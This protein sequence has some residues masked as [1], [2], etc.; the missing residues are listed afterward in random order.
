VNLT[1]RM[2]WF[3]D[4][5][6]FFHSLDRDPFESLVRSWG[7]IPEFEIVKTPDEFM[8]KKPFE[9][10]DLIVVDYNL[11]D[12]VPHGEEFI[13]EIRG[14]NIFTEIIFYSAS[15]ST[16]LWDAI[17]KNQ[18]EGV[19]VSDRAGILQKLESVAFQSVQKV[20][21]L[22][23][24]R[25][26]V[27]AEVGDIDQLLDEILRTGVGQLGSAEQTKIFDGFHEQA[28]EHANITV[29]K[30][31]AFKGA[32]TV[33]L[34]LGLCDS[35]KRWLSLKRLARSLESVKDAVVADYSRD[36][37]GPRNFL[38]HGKPRDS[39]DGYIFVYNTKEYP[40][41][42]KVGMDLR[43]TILDYRKKFQEIHSNLTKKSA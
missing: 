43:K 10:Y 29:E 7:F 16:T 37:L 8:A 21:D 31:T 12:S 19:F 11:G 26:M 13:K 2:L 20:L 33:E 1:Y 38:A 36:V 5:D 42:K 40:F 22:N 25:G 28:A 39:G 24:M 14:H 32:P 15:P 17:Q 6:D 35:Y 27:M 9:K 4:T 30:L 23:N 18:L 34:M 3:D 41:D